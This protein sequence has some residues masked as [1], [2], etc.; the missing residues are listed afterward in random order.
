MKDDILNDELNSH[1]LEEAKAPSTPL[2]VK[3]FLGK[4][5]H[6]DTYDMYAQVAYDN[7][8]QDKDGS[9]WKHIHPAYLTM[10]AEKSFNAAKLVFTSRLYS[11]LTTEDL[12]DIYHSH[13]HSKEF[14]K[15]APSI[16]PSA[17]LPILIRKNPTNIHLIKESLNLR[18]MLTLQ[19]KL[20]ADIRHQQ[21]K[22]K[23]FGK[24][25]SP[26]EHKKEEALF[27]EP[28]LKATVKKFIEDKVDPYAVLG[29]SPTA[30]EDDIKKAYK[31]KA[32][33]LHPDKSPAE[34][35]T[36]KFQQLGLAKDI[37]S[38]PNARKY[39][40]RKAKTQAPKLGFLS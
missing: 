25:E 5:P 18:L 19:E 1:P 22:Q 20:L 17:W 29:V 40:D 30:T 33:V 6:A 8:H 4:S 15:L 14:L 26:F 23:M 3:T 16:Q 31:A 27:V 7:R 2:E 24:G 10:A 21:R 38:N 39:Y 28:G 9:M 12:I 11:Y 36:A 34:D 35:A 13:R 32:I 37:L